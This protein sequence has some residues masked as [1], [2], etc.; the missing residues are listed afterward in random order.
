[1]EGP[2][3]RA[4]WGSGTGDVIVGEENTDGGDTAGGMVKAFSGVITKGGGGG[5]G[6][7]TFFLGLG[8]SFGCGCG[9]GPMAMPGIGSTWTTR[10]C[11]VDCAAT[12]GFTGPCEGCWASG[13]GRTPSEWAFL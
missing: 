4:S 5:G 8:G 9:W 3:S 2:G 10:P 12:V 6:P 1:M 13:D 7:Q 11:G